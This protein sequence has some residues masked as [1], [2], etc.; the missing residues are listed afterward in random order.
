LRRGEGEEKGK[1]E[2]KGKKVYEN[3]LL[4]FPSKRKEE[5]SR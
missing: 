2:R 5:E 1:S 4:G 3:C